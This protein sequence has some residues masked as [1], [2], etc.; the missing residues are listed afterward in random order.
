MKF[1]E[2][3]RIE[4]MVSLGNTLSRFNGVHDSLEVLRLFVICLM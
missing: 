3:N 1:D 2:R 4:W